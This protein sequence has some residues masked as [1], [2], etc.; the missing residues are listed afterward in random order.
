MSLP[1]DPSMYHQVLLQDRSYLFNHLHH[2][3]RRIELLEARV[4][5]LE[6]PKP[7][8]KKHLFASE[9][10]VPRSI[11]A[12]PDEDLGLH[13]VYRTSMQE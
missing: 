13:P 10:L 4:L 6:T 3:L 5:I 9:S 11:W 8:S 7:A 2:A 12:N 1:Y